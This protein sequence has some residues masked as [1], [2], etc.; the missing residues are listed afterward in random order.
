M[1]VATSSFVKAFVSVDMEGLPHIV[2][3]EHMSPGDKLYDE[4]RSIMTDCVLAMVEELH[5][6]DVERVI[7]ADSHGSKINLIPQRMP[8]FVSIVRGNPRSISMVAGGKGT[9][10]ALFL[11]YHAK[12]GTPRSTFDHTMNS[13]VLRMVKLN[14]EESSEFY[15]NAATLGEQGVPVV[16]VAGDKT[17]LD[18]DVARFTPW[19]VR[20]QLKESLARFAAISPS[21]SECLENIRKGVKTAVSNLQSPSDV[22]PL[23][24][25]TP[26]ELEVY[27][28]S[29]AY[30]DIASHLPSSERIG[31][32]G[33]GYKARSMEEAY[34]VTQLLTFVAEGV[35]SSVS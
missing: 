20:V 8:N 18:D 24:L 12:P 30:A 31:G 7:V 6:S 32:W 26:V 2:S 9:D 1:P 15:M 3:S 10:M 16:L 27:F 5:N 34:R 22:K 21:I 17:L 28:T 33:L 29:T 35:R 13:S 14:G 23:R 25:K 11:G 4:A 19:A